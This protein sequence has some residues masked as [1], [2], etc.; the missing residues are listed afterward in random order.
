MLFCPCAVPFCVCVCEWM[1]VCVCVCARAHASVCMRVHARMHIVCV[2][3]CV[4]EIVRVW[5]H[6]YT[7]VHNMHSWTVWFWIVTYESILS[8]LSSE[9]GFSIINNP[10]LFPAYD[11]MKKRINALCGCLD[12]TVHMADSHYSIQWSKFRWQWWWGDCKLSREQICSA[13]LHNSDGSGQF[14]LISHLLSTRERHK[15]LTWYCIS[16][17]VNKMVSFTQGMNLISVDLQQTLLYVL[18]TIW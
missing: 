10:C 18:K 3:M 14:N 2:C 5:M 7:H 1:C 9:C 16:V 11:V 13:V 8:K 4:K 12:N 17:Q 15:S 6:A